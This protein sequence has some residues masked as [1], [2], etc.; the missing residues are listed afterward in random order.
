[1]FSKKL[2][3]VLFYFLTT[4]TIVILYNFDPAQSSGIYPPSLTREWGGFYCAGCGT[5]R[6]LHQLLN[7]NISAALRFNPL[8]VILL[9]YFC[10]WFTPYFIKYF[11]HLD[12]YKISYKKTQLICAIVVCLLY[13]I[14][15]NTSYSALSWLVPPT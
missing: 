15:R 14:L 2:Q 3:L 13:G 7:G 9:P 4:L 8:L 11:Y 12:T 5:F 10:Y 6:G 1:M